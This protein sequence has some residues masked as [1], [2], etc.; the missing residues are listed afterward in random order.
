MSTNPTAAGSPRCPS[1][2]NTSAQNSQEC[3]PVCPANYTFKNPGTG[4]QANGRVDPNPSCVFNSD[5]K[6]YIP[7]TNVNINSTPTAFAAAKTTF[8][9]LVAAKNAEIGGGRLVEAARDALLRAENGRAANPDGYQRARVDYYTLTQGDSWLAGEKNRILAAE[10]NPALQN[11]TARVDQLQARLRQQSQYS[12]I[13]RNTSES[14]L[15]AKNDFKYIVNS[16]AK[17]MD[18]L[19]VEKEKQQREAE[20][21]VQSNM[22]WIDSVLNWI[23][24]LLLVAVIVFIGYRIYKRSSANAGTQ[25][26]EFSGTLTKT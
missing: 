26:V 23:I 25:N 8:D 13:V 1:G 3:F 9:G 7:V 10:I 14:V 18:M 6:Y 22:E 24:I 20:D 4:V 16:F 17:Q 2:W 12:D 19:N 11:Y 15:R 21:R 5:P